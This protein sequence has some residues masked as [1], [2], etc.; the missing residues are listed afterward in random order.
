[1]TDWKWQV[2]IWVFDSLFPIQMT[3]HNAFDRLR[4]AGMGFQEAA[5]LIAAAELDLATHILERSN[6]ATVA[7]LAQSLKLDLRA[8][9]MEY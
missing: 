2:I 3:P 5:V 1:M 7:E 6:S 8:L 9:T 4:I